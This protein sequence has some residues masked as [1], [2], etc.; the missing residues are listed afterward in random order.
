MSKKEFLKLRVNLFEFI[1][2]T[3]IPK[4][5]EIISCNMYE[6]P[7]EISWDVEYIFKIN[8]GLSKE[9]VNDLNNSI[10]LDLKEYLNTIDEQFYL[11]VILIVFSEF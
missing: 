5:D 3:I 2:Q 10:K 1:N 6:L 7:N 4:Y 8:N 9:T 11:L